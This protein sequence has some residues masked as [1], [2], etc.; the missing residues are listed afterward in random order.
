MKTLKEVEE[1]FNKLTGELNKVLEQEKLIKDEILRL[2][3]EYRLIKEIEDKKEEDK[4]A[5][6]KKVKDGKIIDEE[7]VNS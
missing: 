6:T 2:Q 1:Q 3:G 4:P 5:F 7:P